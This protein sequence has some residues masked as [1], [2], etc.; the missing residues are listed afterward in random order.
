[1]IFVPPVFTMNP[2]IAPSLAP[3]PIAVPAIGIANREKPQRTMFPNRKKVKLMARDEVWD[4]LKNHAKQV[5]SERVAKNPDRI[6]YAIQQFEAH[7]IEYQLKNEQTGHFHCWRKSDDKLFQFYAGTGKIQGFT[8]I[9]GIA[10]EV[11]LKA[12]NGTPSV[13]QK[14]NIRQIN[15]SGGIAMVLYPQGFD[16]FKDIIKGV[17]SCPQDFP[18]AG[19]KCLI[20][21]HSNIG[22]DMLMD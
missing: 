12:T 3:F 1:M 8:Q 15:N 9:K 2:V 16:T 21:A 10:L 4:A 14:R 22:C 19:L 7:G 13:L 11:E 6:A 20:V 18:I 5:H 17:K